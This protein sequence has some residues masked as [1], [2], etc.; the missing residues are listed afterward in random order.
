M[1]WSS[2]Y[3]RREQKLANSYKGKWHKWFAWRPVAVEVKQVWLE[4]L[5]RRG[6]YNVLL[7]WLYE[8]RN[9]IEK[10]G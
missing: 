7:N 6:S 4:W 5:E 3:E 2:Y 8:Y 10:D 1:R 9:P